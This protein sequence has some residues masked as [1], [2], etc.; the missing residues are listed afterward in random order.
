MSFMNHSR[1]GQ[2]QPVAKPSLLAACIAFALIPATGFA[3]PTEDTVIVD[4]T[5]QSGSDP[6]RE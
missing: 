2:R 6:T 1:D 4:G 3:A 5:A